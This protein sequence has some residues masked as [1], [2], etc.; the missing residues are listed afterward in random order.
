[1]VR[2]GVAINDSRESMIAFTF[3]EAI[4]YIPKKSYF[5]E[6]VLPAFQPREMSFYTFVDDVAGGL[7]KS[8]TYSWAVESLKD[9][10]TLV[11]RE[12][13]HTQLVGMA[14]T[15]KELDAS[16]ISSM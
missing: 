15:I 9:E 16:T 8:E 7:K 5:N 1:M 6:W 12:I 2:P 11:G 10:C 13:W 3:L 4:E 14:T